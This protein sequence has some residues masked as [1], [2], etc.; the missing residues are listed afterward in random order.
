MNHPLVTAISNPISEH[1]RSADFGGNELRSV[2]AA[3]PP[4]RSCI[5]LGFNHLQNNYLD[6]FPAVWWN[7]SLMRKYPVE[8]QSYG[9]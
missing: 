8:L 9:Y 4:G 1:F 7:F 6:H 5:N 2:G 3:T